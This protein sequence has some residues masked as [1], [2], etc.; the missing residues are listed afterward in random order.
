MCN[1]NIDIMNAIFWHWPSW[2]VLRESFYINMAFF[3]IF[4]FWFYFT[5]C[6]LCRVHCT[7]IGENKSSR[8]I[9]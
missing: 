3:K 1:Q 2:Q 7:K 9:N 5:L 4:F 6:W 8:Q